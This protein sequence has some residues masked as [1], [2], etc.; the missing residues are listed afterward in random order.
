MNN[1]LQQS[2]QQ[3]SMVDDAPRTLTCLVEGK[4]GLFEVKITGNRSILGL[5]DFKNCVFSNVNVM[6]LTLWKVGMTMGQQQH[7]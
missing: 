4:S 6:D 3:S 7:I 5:K 2:P 1:T